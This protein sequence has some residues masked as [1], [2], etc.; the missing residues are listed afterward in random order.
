[1]KVEVDEELEG[2]RDERSIKK[3]KIRRWMKTN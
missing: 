3:R 1:M 2:G